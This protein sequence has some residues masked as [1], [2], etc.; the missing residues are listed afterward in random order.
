MPVRSAYIHVPFCKYRCGYCNFTLIAGRDD[1]ISKYLEALDRE[2]N[3]TLNSKPVKLDTLY[4]GGGTP[5]HL[6]PPDLQHLL[7]ILHSHFNLYP[8]AEF[9]C[10]VNPLDCTPEKLSTLKQA[11]VNRITLG[12][13]SFQPR[14]LHRLQ[15]DHSDDH[16]R[17]ALQNTMQIFDNVSLDLVYAV[18]GETIAE[19]RADLKSAIALNPQ[20]IS[21][22]SLTVDRGSVFYSQVKRGRISEIDD[23]LRMVMYETAIECLTKAGMEHYDVSGFA[24]PG[25]ACRHKD[26]YLRGDPWFA[27]GPGATSY[28]DSVR[29]VNHRSSTTYIRRVLAGQSPVAESEHLTAEQLLGKRL[30]FGLSS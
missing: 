21:T 22:Y 17:K 14:K 24:R 3:R 6:S 23:D 16:L 7:E 5:S 30:V 9:S 26:A 8:K 2:I 28:I 18:P 13:Q 20:H 4:L 12:G 29:A 19:W 1:L 11:G 27:F 10:E 15:R 25:F